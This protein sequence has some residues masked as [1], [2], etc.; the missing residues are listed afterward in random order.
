MHIDC[1][2]SGRGSVERK[3][4]RDLYVTDLAKYLQ[5]GKPLRI[6]I[7]AGGGPLAQ[8]IYTLTNTDPGL[9]VVPLGF[10]PDPNFTQRPSNPLDENGL[11]RL[12]AAVAANSCD[13]GVA[14]D[15]DGDRAV[16]VDEI[17]KAVSADAIII[18]I[19]GRLLDSSKGGTVLYDLRCSRAVSE[20][21]S[22]YGGLPKRTRVGH[23][24]IK[25]EMRAIP[26]LF[27]GELSGHYYYA[28][29]SY[30]D[31]ALRTFIEIINCVRSADK[32]LGQIAAECA[33]YASSGEINLKMAEPSI[34][35]QCLENEFVD[36]TNKDY[37][38]GISIDYADWWFN[39]RISR[40]ESLLRITVGSISQEHLDANIKRVLRAIS[41]SVS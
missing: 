40:T 21:V 34:A 19:A 13:F 5:P 16:F 3:N 37:L 38:D 4:V 20:R 6:A 39:A 36:A 7:D 14:F 12:V 26:A 11:D 29:M 8:E 23:S 28:D 32:P 25:A 33:S 24:F 10:E 18:M 9:T 27:A 1:K 31:N 41:S 30:S 35:L 17:G 22:S 2:P 15:G